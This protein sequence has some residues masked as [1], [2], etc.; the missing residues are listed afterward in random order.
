MK[1]LT[2]FL[3]L[4]GITGYSQKHDVV[5]V[6][7]N[8]KVH[9]SFDKGHEAIKASIL[10]SLGN[11]NL[12]EYAH[13]LKEL[14]ELLNSN[15]LS[16]S[17]WSNYINDLIDEVKNEKSDTIA[18][19]YAINYKGI[20]PLQAEFFTSSLEINRSLKKQYPTVYKHLRD[21]TS[22]LV[23]LGYTFNAIDTLLTIYPKNSTVG[24]VN[25]WYFLQIYGCLIIK[26]AITK[27]KE[28]SVNIEYIMK[29]HRMI[30]TYKTPLWLQ[31]RKYWG[32]IKKIEECKTKYNY[33]IG[34][35]IV[36]EDK[37]GRSYYEEPMKEGVDKNKIKEF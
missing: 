32:L 5:G 34:A 22:K 30:S 13:S 15:K 17:S 11:L 27:E 37:E 23:G 35:D 18:P 24:T 16:F 3:M 10:D 36:M 26:L 33:K 21:E 6:L 7:N 4:I 19:F 1:F 9:I 8:T 25:F 14:Y 2:A 31:I 28:G 12:Y 20:I 29:N